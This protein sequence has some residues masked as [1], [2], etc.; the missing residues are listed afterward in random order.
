MDFTFAQFNVYYNS[1]QIKYRQ[2]K[3]QQQQNNRTRKKWRLIFNSKSYTA[4]T[5]QAATTQTTAADTKKKSIEN[6]LVLAV[7]VNWMEADTS[8]LEA[9]MLRTDVIKKK[10]VASRRL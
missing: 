8:R 10:I 9:R 3:I 4:R 6:P 7:I 5:E 2:T 1:K